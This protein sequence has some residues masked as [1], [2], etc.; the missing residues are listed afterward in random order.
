MKIT[1]KQ[2]QEIIKEEISEIFSLRSQLGLADPYKPADGDENFN[3]PGHVSKFRGFSRAG[4]EV[5]T[6]K[7]KKRSPSAKDMELIKNVLSAH[8]P[9]IDSK[10]RYFQLKQK[11]EF[12]QGQIFIDFVD[13]NPGT[14]EDRAWVFEP[15]DPN[16][17]YKV[18]IAK[19]PDAMQKQLAYKKP[20]FKD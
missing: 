3:K 15:R 4:A 1:K 7:N 6:R 17:L 14:G 11:G 16:T 12:P 5:G 2:L 8:A 20:E 9:N 18:P 13:Y 19:G 10:K